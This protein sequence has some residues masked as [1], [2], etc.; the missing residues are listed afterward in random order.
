MV[1]FLEKNVW[2]TP[3]KRIKKGQ[4]SSASKSQVTVSASEVRSK[5][6]L[7][8]KVGPKVAPKVDVGDII[9]RYI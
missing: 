8:P 3:L 6:N 7:G 1:Y 5:R 4:Y 9:L 2:V